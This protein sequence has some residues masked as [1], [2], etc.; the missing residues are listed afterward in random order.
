M[1]DQENMFST[2]IEQQL[3]LSILDIKN[4]ASAAISKYINGI[5]EL[6]PDVQF[7][8]FSSI[9]E[10]DFGSD[11]LSV[12]LIESDLET[13]VRE[14]FIEFKRSF[15]TRRKTK[16]YIPI[17]C[18]H[19][20]TKEVTKFWLPTILHDLNNGIL[21]IPFSEI[22]PRLKFEDRTP[23]NRETHHDDGL[24]IL[25]QRMI[26][27][28]DLLRIVNSDNQV[29]YHRSGKQYAGFAYDAGPTVTVGSIG[30]K[31]L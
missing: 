18:Q 22:L 21:P 11:V 20:I 14:C 25:K 13:V 7:I 24:D 28:Q 8:N 2:D 30:V 17:T 16:D 6:N 27:I 15:G 4:F 31:K 23:H 26:E 9:Q 5:F 29:L 10:Y 19:P 12:C 1:I 3:N